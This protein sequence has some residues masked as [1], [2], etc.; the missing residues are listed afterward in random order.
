M[1]TKEESERLI[2]A[3]VLDQDSDRIGEVR[4]VFVDEQTEAPVWVGVR[5]GV[6]GGEV[7]VPLEGS[8]WDDQSLHAAVSRS[9]ARTA[10]EVDLDEPLTVQEHETVCRHYGIPTVLHPREDMDPDLFDGSR[11][12]Y[13]VQDDDADESPSQEPLHESRDADAVRRSRAELVDSSR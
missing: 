4:Q 5:L 10:P 9:S 3:T 13:S 2:G 8:E 1:F 12:S 6:F 11:V 7:L